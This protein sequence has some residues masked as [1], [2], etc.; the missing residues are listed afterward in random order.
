MKKIGKKVCSVTLNVYKSAECTYSAVMTTDCSDS[1]DSAVM[2]A[3]CAD[4]ADSIHSELV[5][6]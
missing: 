3:E 2:T 1:A 5:C 6:Q 4:S